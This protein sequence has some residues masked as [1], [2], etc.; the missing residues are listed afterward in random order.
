MTNVLGVL[1]PLLL[2]ANAYGESRLRLLRLKRQQ[3]RNDIR[4][5]TLTVRF[6]GD[7]DA[8]HTNADNRKIL[9]GDTIKNTVYALARQHSMETLEDF[10]LH[11]VEHFLT[12]NP[13]IS[14]VAVD[15]E[16]N[17]WARVP[18]GGKP[19][20]SAFMRAGEESRTCALSGTRQGTAIRSGISNLVLLKTAEVALD[21]FLRDPYTTLEPSHDRVLGTVLGA[22][23]LYASEEVEFATLAQGVRQLFLE[24]FA[25]HSTKSLQHTLYIMG[26]AVLKNFEQIDE[27]HLALPELHFPILDLNPLGMDNPGTVYLPIDVPQGVAEATLKRR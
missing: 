18:Y 9:P 6:E 26:E 17:I 5:L 12:Y 14:R 1:M 27:I 21:N 24:I 16:E 10:A 11:V 20:P 23:W 3:G 22:D 19:H 4:D 25:E 13:Q 2:A 15:A 7:F 8:A